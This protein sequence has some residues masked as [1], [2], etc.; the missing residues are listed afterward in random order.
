MNPAS[1][2]GIT[3]P[4]LGT[5]SLSQ[6]SLRQDWIQIGTE[7][8]NCFALLDSSFGNFADPGVLTNIL[9]N[10]KSMDDYIYTLLIP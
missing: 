2:L 4:Q 6:S 9:D 7:L 3:K 8:K 10:V 1:V 5:V